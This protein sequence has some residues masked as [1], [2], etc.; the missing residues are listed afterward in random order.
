M[1]CPFIIDIDELKM[2]ISNTVRV[3]QYISF[4]ALPSLI[5]SVAQTMEMDA[6]T[7]LE[8]KI[9]N[10]GVSGVIYSFQN[11]SMLDMDFLDLS[12]LRF[13][14]LLHSA[15]SHTCQIWHYFF[16]LFFQL[17]YLHL[18]L[19]LLSFRN[20]SYTIIL[21]YLCYSNIDPWDSVIFSLFFAFVIYPILFSS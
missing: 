10:Q 15:V 4:L 14:Q 12:F 3:T 16:F 11:L 19:F 21:Q 17:N 18:L 2:Q 13:V 1:T 7:R 20:S 5:T 6:L 9:W 8:A